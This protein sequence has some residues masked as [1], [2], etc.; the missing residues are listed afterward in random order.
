MTEQASADYR[1]NPHPR[2]IY[3]LEMR[4]E[5]A[6]G[7]F[8]YVAGSLQFNVG[9]T[10]CLPPPGLNPG[11]RTSPVPIHM[12]PLDVARRADGVYDASIFTDGMIDEDYH[13]RG[14]CHWELANVQL[15]LKATGAPGETLF[16]ASLHGDELGAGDK[17]LNYAR[18][19]FPRS[20]DTDLEDPVTFGQ[21]DR[22]KMASEL[23]AE[24]LFQIILSTARVAP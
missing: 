15:Q 11:G 19:A 18:I 3:R 7:E 4:V 20:P 10:A 9:N 13:G 22:S 8:E 14:T 1:E 24:D 2:R 17:V 5:N 12:I 16:V 21:V 23:S 6:P